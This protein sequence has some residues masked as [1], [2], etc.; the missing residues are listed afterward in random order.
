MTKG[1]HRASLPG[2]NGKFHFAKGKEQ[3]CINRFQYDLHF[4]E[5]IL[6]SMSLPP[7][8]K[9]H[10]RDRLRD[11]RAATLE[12]A[13]NFVSIV[14]VLEDLGK[15]IRH[16]TTPGTAMAPGFGG[17]KGELQRLAMLCHYH[18]L[19]ARWPTYNTDFTCL[20]EKVRD[21]RNNAVHQG[22]FARHLADTAQELSLVLEDALVTED[23]TEMPFES[24]Q[25]FMVRGVVQAELWQPLSYVRLTMLRSSFSYLPV[26]LKGEWNFV[27]DHN[28]ATY[29]NRATN[30]TE[31]QNRLLETLEEAL[32][33]GLLAELAFVCGPELRRKDA[34]DGCN[35]KPILVVDQGHL[36]GV[37][38]P[39]DLL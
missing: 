31:R 10:F 28:L 35:D 30:Q 25:N 38:T 17:Y 19:S 33:N 26:E 2:I 16:L 23:E 36:L 32:A 34:L 3:I 29:L 9:L 27:S 15:R 37:A 14:Q 8:E 20:F 21:G 22:V 1:R 12:D 13:E 24:I 6:G 5:A 18:R 39:F 4:T 7:Q 11:A